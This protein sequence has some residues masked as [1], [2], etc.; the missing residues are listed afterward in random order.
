MCTLEGVEEREGGEP[1]AFSKPVW[2]LWFA[3][4]PQKAP[5]D[6][7][8][9]FKLLQGSSME[10]RWSPWLETDQQGGWRESSPS[11]AVGCPDNDIPPRP[12]PPDS[13]WPV[14][15]EPVSLQK[16]GWGSF[17]AALG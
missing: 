3:A 1:Q 16:R 11:Q 2:S 17:S 13:P 7:G 5:T 15:S 12:P 8:F 10:R 9:T 14:L 6:Q 4:T